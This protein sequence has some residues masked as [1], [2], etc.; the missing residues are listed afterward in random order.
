MFARA[1][2]E[3]KGTAVFKVAPDDTLTE[4]IQQLKR[5]GVGALLVLDRDESLRGII[6]ER[7]I[8]HI[9]GNRPFQPN[10]I[11]VRDIMTPANG[12]LT[13]ALDDSL[14]QMMEKMTSHHVRHLPVLSAGAVVGIISIGDV[15]KALLDLARDENEHL[16]N[17]ISGIAS[18]A[19]L[20][21]T[22]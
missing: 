16:K 4:C 20:S 9:C 1:I 7:D 22:L 11:L 13:A 12:V 6:T 8:L 2:L 17:C 15:I 21:S 14:E 3:R 19:G 5:E 10:H 18:A